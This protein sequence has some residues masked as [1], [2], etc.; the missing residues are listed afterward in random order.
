MRTKL[1][2][3][4]LFITSSCIKEVENQSKKKLKSNL[5]HIVLFEFKNNTSL[6]KIEEIK[7]AALALKKIKGVKNL[8]WGKNVSPEMLNKG[9]T[10][11]LTM[12]FENEYDRDSI[13]LPH[14]T[15]VAFGEVFVPELENLVVYD[16]WSNN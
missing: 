4:I 8:I 6:E 3:V 5:N 1:I 10:H 16:Y 12:S 7:Q 13:Y 14:L 15:H 11:S 2:I 9:L